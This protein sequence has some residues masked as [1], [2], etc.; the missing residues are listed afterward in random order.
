[1]KYIAYGHGISSG[2]MDT[3]YG[4]S[5]EEAGIRFTEQFGHDPLFIFTEFEMNMGKLRVQ[6]AYK[7]MR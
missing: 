6:E 1:M 2:M 5:I 7:R 4:K 3:Q